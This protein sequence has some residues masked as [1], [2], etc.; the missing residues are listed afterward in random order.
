M[1]DAIGCDGAAQAL[2][3]VSLADELI[4]HYRAVRG[5]RRSRKVLVA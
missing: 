3:D 4:D 1:P 2:S 5:V